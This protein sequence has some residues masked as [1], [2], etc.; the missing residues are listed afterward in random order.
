MYSLAIVLRFENAGI[1]PKSWKDGNLNP[2]KEDRIFDGDNKNKRTKEQ[3]INQQIGSIHYSFIANVIRVLT[4]NRPVTKYR[5]TCVENEASIIEDIAKRT[6]IKIEGARDIDK[7]GTEKYLIENMTIRKCLD[8]SWNKGS[9]IISW[10]RIKFLLPEELYNEFVLV[11]NHI[12]KCDSTQM[13]LTEVISILIESKDPRVQELIDKAWDNKCAPLAH[14]L[15]NDGKDHSLQQAGYKGLGAY[16]TTLVTKG[17]TKVIRLDGY[18][19]IPVTQE[20]LELF[21]NGSGVATIFDGG[22]VRIDR[23]CNLEYTT[24]EMITSDY[25]KVQQ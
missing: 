6:C 23:I 20:E 24:L 2:S 9:V 3:W 4:G 18:I 5:N 17:V 11:S 7:K 15:S 8:D 12:C 19:C 10:I 16:L 22:V 14:L 21:R 1:F 13:I 25:Q